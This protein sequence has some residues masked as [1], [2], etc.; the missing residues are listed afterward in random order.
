MGRRTLVP[1]IEDLR[2]KFSKIVFS[3]N[4][5]G[6]YFRKYVI[7]R[8]PRTSAQLD[9]RS[10][11]T[12]VSRDWQSLDATQQAYWKN[13]LSTLKEWYLGTSENLSP[14]NAFTMVASQI[15]TSIE[16]SGYTQVINTAD[17]DLE[18]NTYNKT[19]Q[20]SGKPAIAIRNIESFNPSLTISYDSGIPYVFL[21]VDLTN[22]SMAEGDYLETNDGRNLSFVVW[23]SNPGK[24][25]TSN[26]KPM[27]MKVLS[28]GKLKIKKAG[29]QVSNIQVKAPINNS[30]YK[31]SPL[32]GQY[33][34]YTIGIQAHDGPYAIV[35]D[36]VEQV[37][38]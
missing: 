18:L 2:G 34:R 25:L 6:P 8:N 12:A 9:M 1:F 21:Q 31:L 27:V 4:L 24:Y 15:K 13:Y 22:N 10:I 20:P 14:F 32:V 19:I 36:G 35:L 29:S 38:L 23:L 11:I 33:M 26:M 17:W 16:V 5:A 3:S 37:S 7:P 28:T 30:Y